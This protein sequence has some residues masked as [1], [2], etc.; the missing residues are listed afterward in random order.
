MRSQS[1]HSYNSLLYKTCFRTV[2]KEII[3]FTIKLFVIQRRIVSRTLSKS[4]ET[5]ISLDHNEKKKEKN[6]KIK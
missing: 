6:L 5:I 1:N 2:E 4:R 3:L